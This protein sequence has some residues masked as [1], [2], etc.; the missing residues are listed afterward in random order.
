MTS[1]SFPQPSKHQ[2]LNPITMFCVTLHQKHCISSMLQ[3]RLGKFIYLILFNKPKFKVI[4]AIFIFEYNKI[5]WHCSS[6]FQA[7]YCCPTLQRELL[8]GS[9]CKQKWGANIL[10]IISKRQKWCW[11]SKGSVSSANSR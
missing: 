3:G 1:K 8:S 5:I 2:H 7:V 11:Y 4:S 10:D 6:L 9:S